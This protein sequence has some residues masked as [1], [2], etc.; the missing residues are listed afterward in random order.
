MGNASL[1][2]FYKL[3]MIPGMHHCGGS[4]GAPWYT[5]AYGNLGHSVLGY[6]DPQHDAILA[7]MNWVENGTAPE[8]L[9]ATKFYNDIPAKGVERQRP[10]CPYPQVAV[11]NGTGNVDKSESWACQ[12]AA[13]LSF[14]MVGGEKGTVNSVAGTSRNVTSTTTGSATGTA[15]AGIPASTTHMGAAVRSL[16][17]CWGVLLALLAV[18]FCI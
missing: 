8:S 4:D 5:A 11:Y 14:P 9:I 16:P 2:D 17:A 1:D 13:L 6:E 7:M 15:L 18:A 10:I 3:F 12:A